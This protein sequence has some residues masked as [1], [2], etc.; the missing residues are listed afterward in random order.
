MFVENN[1]LCIPSDCSNSSQSDAS[2]CKLARSAHSRTWPTCLGR[3]LSFYDFWIES[4]WINLISRIQ[5]ILIIQTLSMDTYSYFSCEIKLSMD[6]VTLGTLHYLIR[7]IQPDSNQKSKKLVWFKPFETCYLLK[8]NRRKKIEQLEIWILPLEREETSK[9]SLGSHHKSNYLGG[10]R[11]L[12][13][14]K[15]KKTFNYL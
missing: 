9:T 13:E 7:W 14:Y 15:T 4:R 6:N 1:K 12:C 11:N 8:F 2:K 10:G 5:L 3:Q